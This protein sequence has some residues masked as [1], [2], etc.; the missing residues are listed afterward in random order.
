MRRNMDQEADNHYY[1]KFMTELC[2][3]VQQ[4]S[5]I[6]KLSLMNFYVDFEKYIIR[7]MTKILR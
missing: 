6:L 2:T 4:T 7:L 1:Q 5:N 3:T